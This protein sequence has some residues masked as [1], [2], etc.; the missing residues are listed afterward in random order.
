MSSDTDERS[1]SPEG[2][3]PSTPITS[4]W[5]PSA[6]VHSPG[7]SFDG[8]GPG[9]SLAVPRMHLE[10]TSFQKDKSN[11]EEGWLRQFRNYLTGPR[12]V[13]LALADVEAL[14]VYFKQIKVLQKNWIKAG[15]MGFVTEVGNPL[16]QWRF[17]ST[18]DTV[19]GYTWSRPI[20]VR[21]VAEGTG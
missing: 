14:C 13:Q 17:F 19:T 15:R 6:M 9:F 8:L 11:F 4:A 1:S 2:T 18:V 5:Q 20:S 12:P 3:M 10:A 21:A 16:C 7:S